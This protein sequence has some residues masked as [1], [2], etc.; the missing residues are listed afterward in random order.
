MP[1]KKILRLLLCPN[2]FKGSLTAPQAAQ[3]MRAGVAL[4]GR[5][6][7]AQGSPALQIETEAV[8]LADG[9]DGTLETLIAATQGAIFT[10]TVTGPLSEPVRARWGRL[11]GAAQDTAIIE[12]AEVAGLRLLR[13]D[14]YDPERAT[15]RGVGQLMRLALEAGC[16]TL[17]IGIGGSATC[18]GGAGMA[19]ALGARLLDAAGN[20]LPPGGAALR[21]LDRIDRTHFA[22][23]P[24]TQVIA[25]C[26]VDNPL[27]GPEG[28]AF[29]YGPQKGA[30]Q[31]QAET[32]DAALSHYGAI[33]RRDAGRNIADIPGAGAAGGLG[34]GLLA[35]CAAQLRPG[36]EMVMEAT[37]F[38]AALHRCDLALTGEGRLDGQ[39]GRGKVI[40]GVAK[41]AK[42]AG[43]PVVALVGSL[44][45]DAEAALRPEGL[46]AALPIL[47]AP[48]STEAAMRDG[49]RL[50]ADATQRVLCLVT[51]RD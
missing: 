50:L 39:T 28:A 49:Y 35:F 30:T 44:A 41:R 4:F 43:I 51:L 38:D 15:T 24:E 21:N 9:G 42:A 34:A 22:L 8:P 29:V 7:S 17:L 20:E 11:G 6:A 13:P 3:A 36:I 27:A 45:D 5:S 2:A 19:Q 48:Q 31:K 25:A 46:S 12:M 1:N 14:Q 33:L 18:D 37:G 47:D 23:P 10:T 26:D 40:A 32:L 16:R